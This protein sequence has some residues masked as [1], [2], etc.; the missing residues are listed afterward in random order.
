MFTN[1][2][3]IGS[4]A[5]LRHTP[6]GKPVC[7]IS[8]AYDVGFGAKKRTG[9][10]EAALWGDRA[11]KL[12]PHLTKGA[13]VFAVLDDVELETYVKGDGSGGAKIK[14]RIVDIKFAGSP[15]ASGA[16]SQKAG[17]QQAAPQQAPAQN[18]PSGF[19][20]FDGPSF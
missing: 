13:R 8:L 10:I 1:L 11:E 18:A 5:I 7:N 15:Q 16:S 12:A 9:W 19:D 4:D 6:D 17:P 20:D 2:F 3:G 14:A